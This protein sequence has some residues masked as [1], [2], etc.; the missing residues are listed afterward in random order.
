[1]GV[2]KRCGNVTGLLDERF[3]LVH[4]SKKQIYFAGMGEG[5]VELKA[6]Y[7]YNAFDLSIGFALPTP[8][9]HKV[10]E[11]EPPCPPPE[12][13]P[14]PPAKLPTRPGVQVETTIPDRTPTAHQVDPT[15]PTANPEPPPEG[16]TE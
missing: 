16:A 15:L 6:G 3:A 7:K 13:Q 10:G 1:M 14:G 8:I 12:K 2:Y 5:I 4:E 11:K 9:E